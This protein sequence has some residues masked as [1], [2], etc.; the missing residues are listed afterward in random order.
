MVREGQS[1]SP[2]HYMDKHKRNGNTTIFGAS[3]VTM[4]LF[5]IS[6]SHHLICTS[7]F[8]TLSIAFFTSSAALATYAPSITR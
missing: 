3:Q 4:L 8:S 2:G 6:S 7:M 1:L 5:S